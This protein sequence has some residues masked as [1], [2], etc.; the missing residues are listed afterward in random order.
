MLARRAASRWTLIHPLFALGQLLVFFVSVGYLIAYLRGAVPFAVVHVTVLV[1]IG[2]MAG[3]VVTGALWEHDMFGYWWFA[4]AFLLEDV[5]TLIVF[6][7][8]IAYLTMHWLQ[9]DNTVAVLTMLGLAYTV[10]IANV[11]QYIHK[12]QRV[13]QAQARKRPLTLAA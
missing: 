5:M 7:T 8:Q 9:P 1:K 2:L 4:P 12:T 11:A 13:K 3:A 6:I 10:Y